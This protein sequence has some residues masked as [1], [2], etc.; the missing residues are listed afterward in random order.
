[1][2]PLNQDTVCN[3]TPLRHLALARRVDLLSRVVGGQIRTPRQ[4]FDHEE[5]P[6]GPAIEI[7]E[8]GRSERYFASRADSGEMADKWGRLIEFRN[9]TDI[10]VLDLTERELHLYAEL[11]SAEFARSVGLAARLGPGES[12]VSQSL[13]PAV[14]PHSWTTRPRDAFFKLECRTPLSL[15]RGNLSA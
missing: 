14:G 3:T 4:V 7:S 5:D 1:M 15:R 2:N 8:I 9:R 13:R 6:G 12:A 11:R 10:E